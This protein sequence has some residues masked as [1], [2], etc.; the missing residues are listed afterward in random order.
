MEGF[1]N[2]DLV[3]GPGVDVTCDLLKPPWPFETQSV[4]GLHCEHF[5]EHVP[6]LIAFMNEAWRV[7]VVGALF[8]IIHPHW[9]SHR[10]WM[11]PTHIR[12]L[13]F[14]AWAY[15][16]KRWREREKLDHYPITCNWHVLA[17]D[18]SLTDEWA[19]KSPEEQKFAV[20]HYLDVC[21][22]S[23]IVLVSEP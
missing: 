17:A 16:D 18:A 20:R 7:C 1:L 12:P 4:T 10:A 11:D 22:D 13:P 23:K 15:Y 3:D 9:T 21:I 14:E 6:D 2:V 8:T 19:D 5:I